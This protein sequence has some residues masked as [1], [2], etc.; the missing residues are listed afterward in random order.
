MSPSTSNTLP[1]GAPGQHRP[2]RHRARWIVLGTLVAVA[3]VVLLV[4]WSEIVRRQAERIAS[5]KTG[6]TVVIESLHI[7]FRLPLRFELG[8]VSVSNPEWAEAPH[9]FE[10]AS[11]VVE[12]KLWPLIARRELM[13][14]TVQLDTPRVDMQTDGERNTWTFEQDEKKDDDTFRPRIGHASIR[15]GAIRFRDHEGADVK[16]GFATRTVDGAERL[17][18]NAKGVFR[19]ERIDLAASTGSVLELADKE[20][21][22]VP[23]KINGTIGPTRIDADG[24]LAELAWPTALDFDLSVKGPT[25]AAIGK[26][27]GP[28]IPETPPYA[29]RGK[30]TQRD[31]TWRWADLD[32]KIGDSLVNGFVQF[33]PR[34]Q[35]ARPLLTASLTLPRLDF[36]D[37]A[38]LIGAPPST[39]RGET[40]SAEQKRK[41]RQVQ[42]T[43][44]TLPDQDFETDKWKAIDAKVS[45][46]AKQVRRAPALPVDAFSAQM[47]LVDG[48]VN[49]SPLKL[50]LAGGTATAHV[51]MDSTP[52]PL[53]A[54]LKAQFTGLKL[55]RMFPTVDK[56]RSSLGTLYGQVDLK[57][58]GGSVKT[59]LSSADGSVNAAMAGG[60][61]SNVLV[62]AAGLDGGEIIKFLVGRDQEI[63]I[64]CAVADLALK[65][66][67]ATTQALVF[68]TTDSKVT[69][70]G[71]VSLARETLDLTFRVKPKDM[72]ILTARAPL[73]LTGTFA[74]PKVAPDVGALAGRGLAALALGAINPLLALIPTIETGGGQ[75]ADCRELIAQVPKETRQGAVSA[76]AR[77]AAK[78][79]PDRRA[80]AVP[81]GSATP[82][83]GD[84]PNYPN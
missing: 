38:P 77:D 47:S 12:A 78:L 41:L 50:G 26:L 24:Q 19:K 16:A 71:S 73:H 81:Q 65:D 34:P 54:S 6:R 79:P 74:K 1:R 59:L 27:F 43:G 39:A 72:S 10:M 14:P 18:A 64:R 76:A 2:G 58:Q 31:G 46:E 8:R 4:D 80:D 40:A 17:E 84:R 11:G 37:L 23:L 68:D 45:I 32:G 63:R 67:V 30:L 3:L 21:G 53:D 44:K 66:G 42:T 35:A 20:A 29:V 61:I 83:V 60:R 51:R 9:F 33:E 25:I 57:A 7:P 75:D 69:G 13:L 82:R 49:I 48:V 15:D 22:P 5:A 52:K 70:E 36:D 56:M 55:D 28:A 62:E